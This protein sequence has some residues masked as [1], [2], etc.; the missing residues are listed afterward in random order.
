[1]NWYVITRTPKYHLWQKHGP[2]DG[3]MEALRTAARMK[4]RLK[5]YGVMIASERE[6]KRRFGDC[7][8]MLEA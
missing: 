7:T 4:L 1:M 5:D 8:M 6:V 3:R 2:I